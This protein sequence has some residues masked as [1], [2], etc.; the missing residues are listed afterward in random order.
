MEQ[1]AELEYKAKL[2]KENI[3]DLEREIAVKLSE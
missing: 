2:N 3:T 1:N